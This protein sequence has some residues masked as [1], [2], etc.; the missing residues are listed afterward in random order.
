MTN[1]CE[2]YQLPYHGI[3]NQRSG[4]TS[5]YT[6]IFSQQRT[7]DYYGSDEMYSIVTKDTDTFNNA[8]FIFNTKWSYF[9]MTPT[10]FR[11][12]ANTQYTNTGGNLYYCDI[13]PGNTYMNFYTNASYYYFDKEIRVNGDTL[14]TQ[15]YVS[16]Y[17]NNNAA[18]V[19]GNL[20]SWG[21]V[22][23][24]GNHYGCG[25]GDSTNGK[26]QFCVGY[27]SVSISGKGVFTKSISFST[28]FG[29]T[30]AVVAV[31]CLSYK[32]GSGN[33]YPDWKCELSVTNVNGSS[34]NIAAACSGWNGTLYFEWIAIGK[35]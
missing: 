7:T 16:T 23:N 6:C 3:I 19:V 17:V 24:S 34:F 15:N 29:S 9:M 10:K 33:S 28:S 5:K 1:L 27:D 13:A 14:A 4:N 32:D 25:I 18:K 2:F 8:E 22:I 21:G 31:P 11:I 26:L 12:N 30:P 35:W 20:S